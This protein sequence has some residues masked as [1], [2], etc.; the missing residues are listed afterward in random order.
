AKVPTRRAALGGG[1]ERGSILR[2]CSP[3]PR[4]PRGPSRALVSR[5]ATRREFMV[6]RGA[7]S[8]F[9]RLPDGAARKSCGLTAEQT[10]RSENT[11]MLPVSVWLRAD[12]RADVGCAAHGPATTRGTV[13]RRRIPSKGLIPLS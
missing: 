11:G 8:W 13:V 2:S 1:R 6:R 9:R 12:A 10:R 4:A 7:V 5:L 3:P